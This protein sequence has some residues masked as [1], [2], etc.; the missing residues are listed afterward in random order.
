M[1]ITLLASL[2]NLVGTG[3][4][5][6]FTT[7]TRIGE[8]FIDGTHMETID[9]SSEITNHPVEGGYSIAD[10]IYRNPLKVKI[11]GSIT[12]ASVDIVGTAKDFVNLFDGNL[13]NNVIDKFRGK[14]SKSTAAYELLKDMHVNKAVFTVVNYLDTFDNMVIETLTFPRDNTIGNRLFFE[15]TLKQITLAT[16]RTVNISNNPRGVR[17]V[18]SNKLETGRQQT[19]V[20]STLETVKGRSALS[21]IFG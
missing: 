2:T 10:H 21:N 5:L 9:Y 6:L 15:A 17:D 19:K 8:L 12:D 18:I 11:E 7:Q 13:L 20:P 4:K 14:G 16:V 1:A 3:K